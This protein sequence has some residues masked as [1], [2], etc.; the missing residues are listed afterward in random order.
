MNLTLLD[1]NFDSNPDG[2][3]RTLIDIIGYEVGK[4]YDISGFRLRIYSW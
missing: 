4:A 1:T 2:F 3:R